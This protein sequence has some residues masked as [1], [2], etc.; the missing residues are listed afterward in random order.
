[1]NQTLSPAAAKPLKKLTAGAIMVA[2]AAVLSL[3]AVIK[4]PN[5]GSITIASMVPIIAY[6][7][8]FDI[9]WAALVSFAY[10]AVQMILGFYPPPAQTFTAFAAVVLLDYVIAFAV[11]C[12][13]GPIARA[14]TKATKNAFLSSLIG[15]GVVIAVRFVCHFLSGITVWASFC[16]EGQPLWL[17]SLLYNGSFMLGEFVISIVVMALLYPALSRISKL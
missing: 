13:A 6:S 1:M 4:L 10:S 14:L 16:P 12:L 17:Y 7:M 9:K 8:L 2:L 3:F 15:T 11:L 5:G